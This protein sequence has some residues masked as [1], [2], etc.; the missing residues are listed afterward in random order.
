MRKRIVAIAGAVLVGVAALTIGAKP[1]YA[2]KNTSPPVVTG[3][4]IVG[5]DL[6]CFS[7]SWTRNPTT[8]AYSWENSPDGSTW[9][10]IGGEADTTYTLAG[11]D[12]TKTV[13]C[14]VTASK[15]ETS[16]QALSTAVGPITGA[17]GGGDADFFV[18][19]T[20][21][22]SNPGTE[23]SPFLTMN[24]CYQA[25]SPGET[26]DMAGGTYAAQTIAVDG[27]KVSSTDV[28]IREAS[29]ETVLIDGR[30]IVQG[31]HL[32]IS[33]IATDDQTN[34]ALDENRGVTVDDGAEDV[35]LDNLDAT[36]F[37]IGDA[38]S[39]NVLGGDYGP[40]ESNSITRCL[41]RVF[42]TLGG[43]TAAPGT[44]ILIDGPVI[45][46]ITSID[47]AW[48]TDGLALFGADGVIVRNT[49]MYNIYYQAII[50]QNCCGNGGPSNILIENNTLPQPIS[51]F[52][53]SGSIDMCK[54]AAQ[55]TYTNIDVRF[56][57][58]GAH[59]CTCT[60]GSCGS[61]GSYTNV[62]SRGNVLWAQSS[63]NCASSAAG[64]TEEYNI[65]VD[66]VD[67]TGT[68]CGTN[69]TS[70]ASY[71]FVNTSWTLS[72]LDMQLSGAAGSTAADNFVPT[73]ITGGCPATDFA[74]ATRPAGAACDA[75][76]YER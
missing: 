7:G 76:A 67:P 41:S 26:C 47:A 66:P 60:V 45:H 58:L 30:I 14:R 46:D 24:K 50:I 42:G 6:A 39:V 55:S 11:G 56:N 38:D 19:T 75:G 20:G 49:R 22:D 21:N 68:V 5:E 1:T 74:G 34:T 13:R 32:T 18:A 65:T 51:S 70:V 69:G 73:S 44:N 57:S 64:V 8:Y 15:N 23:G 36:L 37:D 61:A 17:G 27:T 62:T 59:L 2:P 72:S 54:T 31:K 10:V 43:G 12:E 3:S 52:G 4:T 63:S 48:H 16:G 28:T 9:S 71:P 25:M 40:C 29:G 35:T 53:S 33:D